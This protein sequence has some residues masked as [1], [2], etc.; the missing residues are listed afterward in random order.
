M[1]IVPFRIMPSQ[2]A[3]EMLV[4]AIGQAT[5]DGRRAEA[6]AAALVIERGLLW[7]ADGL[8]ESRGSLR[9]LGELRWVAILP[10]TA[11]FAVNVA[12]R[13]VWVNRFRYA[14]RRPRA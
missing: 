2:R 1:E 10:M 13:E 4:A 12:R 11:W 6:M 3:D 9:V 14:A 8:G 5:A 7:F